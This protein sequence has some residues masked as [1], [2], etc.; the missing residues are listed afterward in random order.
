M[1]F[2]ANQVNVYEVQLFPLFLALALFTQL[3]I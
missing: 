3:I 1:S 2:K